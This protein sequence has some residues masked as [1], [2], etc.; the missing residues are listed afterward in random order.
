MWSLD[1][2]ISIALVVAF[3]LPGSFFHVDSILTPSSLRDFCAKRISNLP[4]A[5][6]THRFTSNIYTQLVR[7]G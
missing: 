2:L 6:L 3:F 1:W 4:S 7:N 5:N